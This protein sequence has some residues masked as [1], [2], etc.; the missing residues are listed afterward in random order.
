MADMKTHIAALEEAVRVL[1]EELAAF[2]TA[3]HLDNILASYW[4]DI[5]SQQDD[6]IRWGSDVDANII[7]FKQVKKES[8]RWDK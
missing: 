1:A 7:A 2:R 4:S 3:P 6:L 8:E 5:D